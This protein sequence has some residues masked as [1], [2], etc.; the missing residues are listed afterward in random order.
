[1]RRA[2]DTRTGRLRCTRRRAI[3]G[4]AIFNLLAIPALS[5]LTS[6]ELGATRSLVHRDAQFYV[7][8][9]LVLFVTFALGAPYVP[10]GT[11]S[12]AILPP[13]WSSSWR[14]TASLSQQDA[15]SM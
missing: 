14:P 15:H 6:E 12:E 10:G 3:V 7:I 5:A 9:V 2:T 13:G 11:N 1:M 4:S 8:G